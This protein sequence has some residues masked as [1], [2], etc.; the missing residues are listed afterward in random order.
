METEDIPEDVLAIGGA[1][2]FSAPKVDVVHVEDDSDKVRW[3][4][5]AERRRKRE[6]Y[7]S[8]QSDR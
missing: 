4:E 7:A 2:G 8:S 1:E 6:I 3:K 5:D